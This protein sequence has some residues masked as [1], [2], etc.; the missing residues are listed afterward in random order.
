[1]SKLPDL[2]LAVVKHF[3]A[4]SGPRNAKLADAY[5]DLEGPIYDRTRTLRCQTVLRHGRRLGP[6]VGREEQGR[7]ERGRLTLTA[8]GRQPLAQQLG[9]RAA[10]VTTPEQALFGTEGEI[11]S[12]A[13]ED[14]DYIKMLA[15]TNAMAG[16]VR[17]ASCTRVRFWDW[18]CEQI[19]L[20]VSKR[21]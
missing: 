6:I 15:N 8:P 20:Y 21:S 17:R 14:V 5:R 2:A 1:M 7:L 16:V 3:Q 9:A 19:P 10:P 4:V 11:M 13:A 18:S 12:V